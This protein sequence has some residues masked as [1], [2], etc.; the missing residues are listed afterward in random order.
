MEIAQFNTPKNTSST[1]EVVRPQALSYS[2]NLHKRHI[3]TSLLLIGVMLLATVSTI[4]LL[5]QAA[6]NSEKTRLQEMVQSQAR[7]IN[8]VS[9]FDDLYSSV[10]YLEGS[11]AATISQVLDAHEDQS[12]LGETGE[13]QLAEQKNDEISWILPSRHLSGKKIPPP[14][15]ID[16]V[17]AEPM[18][19]AL[20]G[21]SGTVVGL[22]YRGATVLAAYTPLKTPGIRLGLVAKLDVAEIRAPFIQA[23]IISLAL[24][25]LI[26][27]IGLIPLRRFYKT[28]SVE[29]HQ[30]E[31]QLRQAQKLEAVGQLAAGVA[32]EINTPTQFVG[33]N[34]NF[35]KGACQDL[36]SLCSKFENF[37][38]QVP[39]NEESNKLKS[40]IESFKKQID[41]DFLLEDIN[42]AIDQS[43]EGTQRIACIVK[44]MKSFSHPGSSEKESSDLNL[45]IEST[46]TVASNEWKYVADLETELDPELPLV[47]CFPGEINQTILNMIV[48][49]THAIEDKQKS[50]GNNKKGLI[51]I[52]TQH[53]DNSALIT[54]SDNGCGIPE[55]HLQ[56]IYDPFFTTKEVGKGSG[57]GLSIA[58]SVITDKHGGSLKVKSK[59]GAGSCFEITLPIK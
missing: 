26:T 5:Y 24:V 50:T 6:F 48:N 47:S 41:L 37:S 4:A 33:D 30:L 49:A 19:R 52:T 27:L 14:I 28:S 43:I 39:D 2:D 9:R 7:L 18:R 17:L 1:Q 25:I 40:E 29:H 58:Y 57:Q 21:D 10:S 20:R 32:H 59:P 35:L 23:G 53:Q 36:Q 42:S 56:K 34:I 31:G 22:D 3:L 45:A 8:A 13:F 51:K 54:V 11:A 16:G 38:Q 46:I 12:T 55:S 44:A 15:K